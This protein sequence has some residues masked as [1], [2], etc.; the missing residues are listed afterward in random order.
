MKKLAVIA[1]AA[2]AALSAC[3][4]V[5]TELRPAEKVTFAV[6]SYAPATKSNSAF[7]TALVFNSRAFLHGNGIDTTQDFFGT[8]AGEQIYWDDAFWT[9]GFT[10]GRDYFWPFSENSWINFV[11]WYDKNDAPDTANLSETALSWSFDGQTGAGHRTLQ[12]DDVILFADEAW[13]YTNNTNNESHYT[14][15]AIRIGVPVLFHNALAQVAFNGRIADNCSMNGAD[16]ASSTIKWNVTVTAMRLA[17]VYSTGT[18]SLT[19]ADPNTAATTQPWT[20]TGG[21]WVTSG[22]GA[23][24]DILAAAD[25]TDDKVLEAANTVDFLPLSTV[26]P[27]PVNNGMILTLTWVITTYRKVNGNWVEFSKENM[28]STCNLATRIP[29]V[30]QWAMGHR[31]TYTLLFDPTTDTIV[32]QPTL[33]DWTAEDAST[34]MTVE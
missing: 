16:E 13:R 29:S 20:V 11:C 24:L 33:A 22:T 18:L 10:S 1:I 31:V 19:N 3:T 8:G 4:K 17:N 5:E 21:N 15:D 23:N 12:S 14:G 26:L 2:L 27:Q 6:G 30:T 28:S 32:F 34:G 25:N 7:S 9:P